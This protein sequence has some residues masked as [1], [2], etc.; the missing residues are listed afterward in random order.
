MQ[1]HSKLEW[2]I[3]CILNVFIPF[4]MRDKY[5]KP[6]MSQYWTKHFD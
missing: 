2:T 5:Q 4:V 6:V 3:C 1:L